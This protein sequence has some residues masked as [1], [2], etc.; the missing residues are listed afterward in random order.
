[1]ITGEGRGIARAL[2]LGLLAARGEYIARMD[3][4]DVARPERLARQIQVL[5]RD[6]SLG[7]VGSAYG[8]ID[9]YGNSLGAMVLPLAPRAIGEALLSRNCLAHPTVMMRTRAVKNVGGYR[10]QFPHARTMTCGCVC[11]SIMTPSI[12]PRSSSISDSMIARRPGP[13]FTRGRHP[14]WRCFGRLPAA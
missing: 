5:Q 6:R 10:E 9:R 14:K 4:D 13:T 12:L 8:L 7:A 2:N 3:A 11:P 1:M